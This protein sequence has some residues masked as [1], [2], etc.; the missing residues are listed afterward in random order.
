MIYI[1]EH[2]LDFDLQTALQLVSAERREQ[3]LRFR[4]E[5][6]QR[7]SVCAY[8]LLQTALKREY[9][10]DEKPH[11]SYGEHGKPMLTD[12]P[13]IHFSL[14][15]CREAV[16]CAISQHPIG[17]DIER[18]RKYDRSLVEY[19]MNEEEQQQI[20]D[21][22][23][24]E[25]AFTR[26]WTMKESLLKFEGTGIRNDLKSVLQN[27]T[28]HFHTIMQPQYV[29]TICSID[30]EERKRYHRNMYEVVWINK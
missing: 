3:A 27:T 29:C 16:A 26:L 9:G 23:E 15:H 17:I 21:S 8:R 10:I 2:P 5:Q 6:G 20:A 24:P 7:L 28:C 22:P 11:F 13:D 25:S 1:D 19:T 4:H 30:N 18:I 12:H 14:S